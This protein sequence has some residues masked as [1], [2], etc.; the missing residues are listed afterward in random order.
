MYYNI[1]HRKDILNKF[2]KEIND[3]INK[4]ILDYYI[5]LNKKYSEYKLNNIT[6]INFINLIPIPSYFITLDNITKNED[7]YKMNF[8]FPSSHTIIKANIMLPNKL[9]SPIP[10][11]FPYIYNNIIKIV[12][13]NVYYYELTISNTIIKEPWND[14][15][16]SIGFGSNLTD[17]NCNLLGWTNNSIGY[18]SFNG[19]IYCWGQ[20]DKQGK[21]YGIGDTVGAGIIYKINNTYTIFFT[22]NGRMIESFDINNSLYSFIPM[23][24][25][26]YNTIIEINQST[27]QFKYDFTKHITQ[28]ILSI[29]NNFIKKNLD[30]IKYRVFNI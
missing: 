25:F 12:D 2:S 5:S 28:Y 30:D 13:S 6:S 18:S 17:T 7:M 22:L 9:Y 23:I 26:N 29:N 19:T 14:M 1:I 8:D 24:G 15:N 10:F 4:I 3:N 27:K 11:S 20:K 16:I 21:M